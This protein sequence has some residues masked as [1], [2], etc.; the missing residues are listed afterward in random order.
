MASKTKAKPSRREPAMV[1]TILEFANGVRL[2]TTEAVACMVAGLNPGSRI[3]KYQLVSEV[4]Q[5]RTS[6]TAR[7]PSGNGESNG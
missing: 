7:R 5:Y 1:L 6:S 2:E 4:T 3:F